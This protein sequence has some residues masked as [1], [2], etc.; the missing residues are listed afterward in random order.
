MSE[1]NQ[2][3]DDQAFLRQAYQL[4]LGR[5]ASDEELQFLQ[6]RLETGF[7]RKIVIANLLLSPEHAQLNKKGVQLPWLEKKKLLIWK[8]WHALLSRIK[9][10]QTLSRAT[11][12]QNQSFDRLIF[13]HNKDIVSLKKDGIRS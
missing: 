12:L 13:N 3:D 1:L 2:L 11:V 5:Q 9:A 6:H 7:T 8:K 4:I 10:I